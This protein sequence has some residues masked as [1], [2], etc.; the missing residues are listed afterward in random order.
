[1]K[2]TFLGTR[3]EIGARTR[4]HRM[5]SSLLVSLRGREVMIDCGLDWLGN[6][7]RLHPDAIVL[8]HAH[9]D[10]AWGLRK[11]AS[12]PVH[13]P[14]ETWRTLPDY[15]I[16]HP[17]VIEEGGPTKICG[18]NFQPFSVEHSILA[19]AVGYRISAGHA[20]IFY[21]PDLLFIHNRAAALKDVQIYIGDG[22]AITR[23]FVRKR[24]DRLIGHANVRTQ[25]GWCAKEGVPLVI[26]THCG[27]EIVTGNETKLAKELQKIATD[28]GIDAFIACDG[29][30]LDMK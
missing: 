6:F 21:G 11:G 18:I 17:H 1:M 4:R 25:L 23:S 10:H 13:A 14:K 22:A 29:M 30:M 27:S 28:R 8:T 24:G 12:C 3:G 20:C 2:L 26:I 7:E 19:P 15:K 16:D 5:H 9:P